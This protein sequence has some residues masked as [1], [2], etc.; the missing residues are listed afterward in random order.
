MEIQVKKEIT[1]KEMLKNMYALN[2]HYLEGDYEAEDEQYKYF[3]S[4]KKQNISAYKI[5][6]VTNEIIKDVPLSTKFETIRLHLIFEDSVLDSVSAVVKKEDGTSTVYS[7]NSL[8]IKDVLN[9]EG[10]DKGVE[11]LKI[12]ALL[13]NQL[14]EVWEK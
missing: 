12:Y 4:L 5:N 14:I 9:N 13:D 3:L 11:V 8:S 2:K 10:M 7:F 6:K 1:L